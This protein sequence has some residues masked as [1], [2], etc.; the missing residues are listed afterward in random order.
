[1][2]HKFPKVSVIIP[3]YNRAQFLRRAIKSVLNQTFQDFELIVVDDGSTDD[4]R[5]VVEFFPGIKYIYQNNSGGAGR[6][7]NTGIKTAKGEY[8]AILDD[9]DEWFTTK[10]EK[11]VQFLE[12][13]PAIDIVGCN[14]L[15]NGKKEYKIP[16]QKDI[17]KE[18][19]IA[20][21]IG[22]GSIMVYRKE[23]FDR[24]GL[25]DENLR[26][27]QD[28][29]MRI[30]LAQ[31]YKF[32]FIEEPLVNYYI[33]HDNISLAGLSVKEREKD[34]QYI[35]EKY[36]NYYLADKK[37][38]SDKLRYDGTRYMLLGL[39]AKARKSFLSSIKKNPLNIK[40]FFYLF[41]S[42]SGTSFYKRLA[43]IKLW[44]K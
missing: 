29:E 26:S 13:N 42:L 41:L 21:N 9:D 17:F 2:N 28:K 37:L 6:P 23:V 33:G 38:Y 32:G 39:S 3:T 11:Q 20:D 5:K 8:I 16:K 18:I 44:I 12:Q 36:K 1:M 27:S 24:V 43:K 22:P 7:K 40:S 19:L 15:I 4:T 31:K 14:Y 34:W 35:F 30:R 25:F 10:L